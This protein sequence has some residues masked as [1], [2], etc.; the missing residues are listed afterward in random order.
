MDILSQELEKN[1]DPVIVS[2]EEG[3]PKTKREGL[4]GKTVNECIKQISGKDIDAVVK[5]TFKRRTYKGKQKNEEMKVRLVAVYNEEKEKYHIHNK[6]SERHFECKRHFETVWSKM[7]H[8][9]AF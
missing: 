1:T 3:V 6:H 4:I 5:I 2:I 9:T 8:R 7:G